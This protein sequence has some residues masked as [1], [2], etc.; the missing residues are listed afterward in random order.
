MEIEKNN[1]LIIISIKSKVKV[2]TIRIAIDK[3][4]Q[5]I[6]ISFQLERKSENQYACVF[7]DWEKKSI[8]ENLNQIKYKSYDH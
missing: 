7:G 8:D 2:T 1:Q 3:E 6:T 4:Y 5:L